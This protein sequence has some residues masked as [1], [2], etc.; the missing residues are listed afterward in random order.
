MILLIIIVEGILIAS[1]IKKLVKVT[2]KVAGKV[3][4]A[5]FKPFI[6]SPATTTTAPKQNFAGGIQWNRSVGSQL[7]AGTLIK[8][9]MIAV[10]VIAIILFI[11]LRSVMH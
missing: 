10:P 8:V 3:A 11:A 7:T 9:K 4:S 2:G 6:G 5:P 1:M